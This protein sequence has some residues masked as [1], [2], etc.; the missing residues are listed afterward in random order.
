MKIEKLEYNGDVYYYVNEYNYRYG[1]FY[2]F[3]NI[4]EEIIFCEKSD[5]KYIPVE[6]KRILKKLNKEF[7]EIKI[8]DIV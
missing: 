1:T 3:A 8:K 5:N 2:K 6:N 7:P 4:N